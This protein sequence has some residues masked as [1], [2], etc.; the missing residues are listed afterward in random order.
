[1]ITAFVDEVV[2]GH[3]PDWTQACASPVAANVASWRALE[4]AGFAYRGTFGSEYGDC[5]LMVRDAPSA[6]A[7][8]PPSA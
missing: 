7:V 2:F 8:D 3:H 5:R 6:P 1:M 4:K